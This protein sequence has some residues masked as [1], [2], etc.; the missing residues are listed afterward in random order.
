MTEIFLTYF[1]ESSEVLRFLSFMPERNPSAITAV[2]LRAPTLIPGHEPKARNGLQQ[3]EMYVLEGT[4]T[5]V[6]FLN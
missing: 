5:I 3:V 6:N 4:F 2:K 1:R